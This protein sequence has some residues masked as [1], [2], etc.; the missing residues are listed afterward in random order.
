MRSKATTICLI[1]ILFGFYVG[2]NVNALVNHGSLSI[3]AVSIVWGLA[4]LLSLFFAL[5]LFRDLPG[6]N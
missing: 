5:R 2:Y 6:P 4:I 1:S 3:D